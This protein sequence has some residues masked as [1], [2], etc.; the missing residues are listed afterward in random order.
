[1]NPVWS[2]PSRTVVGADTVDCCVELDVALSR[3]ASNMRA[4][5]LR[6]VQLRDV[7]HRA[8]AAAGPVNP[9]TS[10]S[11]TLGPACSPRRICGRCCTARRSWRVGEYFTYLT[12]LQVGGILLGTEQRSCPCLPFTTTAIP[13]RV[14]I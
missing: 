1:M 13:T 2:R 10:A 12:Y 9:F 3:R 14:R 4:G 8:K 11:A 5:L 7:L 6:P